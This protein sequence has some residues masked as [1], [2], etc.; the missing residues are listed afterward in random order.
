MSVHEPRW[1]LGVKKEVAEHIT[2]M[3]ES[4]T[5]N[6][7]TEKKYLKGSA[8]WDAVSVAG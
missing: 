2:T 1:A 7:A 4:D 3:G 8:A 6:E 5:E